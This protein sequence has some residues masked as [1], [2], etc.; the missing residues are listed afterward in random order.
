MQNQQSQSACF[1]DENYVPIVEQACNKV[2][3]FSELYKELERSITIN[4]K[5][6]SALENYSRQLAHLALHYNRMPL[7]LDAEEVMDYLY[8][9]K[10][11][12]HASDSFFK[13]TVHGMRYVC[14]MRG[15]E[16]AQFELP[17]LKG[18]KK[19]PTVLNGSEVKALLNAC[20]LLK[21]RLIIGLCYG[22]G[23]RSSEVQ[24]LQP[25]HIDLE[26]KMLHVHQ[27]KG[28]KDRCVP[29]GELLRK[30]V[31]KYLDDHVPIKYMFENRAGEPMT[32]SGINWV[33]K[34]AARQAGIM[35]GIYSHTLRHSF[36][37]HLLENDVNIVHIKELLGHKRIETTLIYL[38]VAQPKSG[39]VLN[40]LDILYGL[41]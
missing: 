41:K 12:G 20:K 3:G 9:V 29:L 28:S 30:G 32:G 26:R 15:L 16:Y 5:S 6:K 40:P 35:K 24:H 1:R 13:F 23:L 7:D 11:D 22:C 25:S 10:S 21:H 17:S 2:I 19:L 18:P 31:A 27:G 36:A 33:V 14:K 8:Q 38:Q 37:T 34:N 4:G 39:K